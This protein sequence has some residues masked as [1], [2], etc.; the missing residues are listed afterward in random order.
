MGRR[1]P[2]PFRASTHVKVTDDGKSPMFSTK[3]ANPNSIELIPST[4]IWFRQKGFSMA[5]QTKRRDSR[6]RVLEKGEGQRRDGRY[7]FEWTDAT[8]ARHYVYANSLTELRKK[9]EQC[10]RRYRFR[11][12]IRRKLANPQRSVGILE[13]FKV[14]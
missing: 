8:G 3:P 13:R 10:H 5:K 2:P 7:Y 12:H 4:C 1:C 6:G 9:E 14:G 11:R